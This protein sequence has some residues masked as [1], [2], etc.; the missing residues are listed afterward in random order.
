MWH[1]MRTTHL[2]PLAES[3]RDEHFE[4]ASVSCMGQ[5]AQVL[6]QA[7]LDFGEHVGLCVARPAS[8]MNEVACRSLSKGHTFL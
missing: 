5:S 1:M 8:Q 4:Q 3:M 2:L 7:R 6:E